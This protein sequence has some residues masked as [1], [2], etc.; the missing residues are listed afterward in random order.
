M[1]FAVVAALFVSDH[2]LRRWFRY[3]VAAV[4]KGPRLTSYHGT[5]KT[6]M[7][8]LRAGSLALPNVATSA[9]VR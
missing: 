9:V 2:T 3:S 7:W 1:A 4:Q 8:A 6:D 5:N